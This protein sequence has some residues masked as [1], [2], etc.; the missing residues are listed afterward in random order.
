MMTKN[1]RS[2][3]R[4]ERIFKNQRN[5][6]KQKFMKETPRKKFKKENPLH[7]KIRWDL[8]NTRMTQDS[9]RWEINRKRKEA[10][11]DLEKKKQKRK[12]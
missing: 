4:K 10:R 2:V 8:K 11:D 3:E 6:N 9:T 5:M 1:I 7:I 12:K